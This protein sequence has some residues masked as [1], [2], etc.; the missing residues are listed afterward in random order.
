MVC[1]YFEENTFIYIIAKHFVKFIVNILKNLSK[2]NV[3]LKK[4][5]EFYDDF[6]NKLG[7][8]VG[9]EIF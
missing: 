2:Y 8:I 6:F 7:G 1:C 3:G 4:K 5:I 9:K